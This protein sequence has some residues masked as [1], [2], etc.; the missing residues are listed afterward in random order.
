MVE[1]TGTRHISGEDI[2]AAGVKTL[3]DLY[4]FAIKEGYEIVYVSHFTRDHIAVID[5]Q[6]CTE[7]T[8]M[9]NGQVHFDGT[10]S[11]CEKEKISSRK[12]K[13]E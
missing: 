9:V 4:G 11:R 3:Q 1:S 10:N 5:P 2:K 7:Y 13:T 8:W 12:G 6:M